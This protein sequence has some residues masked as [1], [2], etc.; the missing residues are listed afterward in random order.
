M[1]RCLTNKHIEKINLL[2][3]ELNAELN[4]SGRY[5]SHWVRQ[6]LSENLLH[7][8]NINKYPVY[9]QHQH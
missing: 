8:D 4:K 6:K 1:C 9:S 3:L 7:Y 2:G 5:L